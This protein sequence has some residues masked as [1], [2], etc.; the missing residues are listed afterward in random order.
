VCT[1]TRH[2]GPAEEKG[3]A[4]AYPGRRKLWHLEAPFRCS[5][6]GTCLSQQELK[7]LCR[8][9]GIAV[10]AP[11]SPYEL[12]RVL[13][14]VAGE[15]SPVARR[16]HKHLD[17]KYWATILHFTRAH[18]ASMLET[19][20]LA[21]VEC[22]ELAGAYWALTT[23]PEASAPLLLRVYGEVHMLSPLPDAGVRVTDRSSGAHSG[24]PGR[25]TR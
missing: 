16:L 22:G 25:L 14:A 21:A 5:L 1:T 18:S 10:Q 15:P 23:H 11:L 6:L 20:W 19:L 9:L 8:K 13:V 7:A 12:H 3:K 17:R 24:R 4:N 2:R